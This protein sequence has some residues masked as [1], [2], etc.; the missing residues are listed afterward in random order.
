MKLDI[1]SILILVLLTFTII[2]GYKWYFSNDGGLYKEKI[3]QLQK[4]YSDIEKKKS[5]SDFRIL[6]YEKQL[7]ELLKRDLLSIG[8]IKQLENDILISEKEA[9][10]SNIKFKELREELLKNNRRIEEF[11]KNP[12][13]KN[14]DDLLESIKNKTK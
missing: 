11:I 2:F 12:P 9:N 3:T 14:D 6:E 1:K 8:K 13:V 4:K 7:D 10:K 5:E